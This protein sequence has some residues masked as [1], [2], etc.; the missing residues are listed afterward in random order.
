VFC[1]LVLVVILSPQLAKD[2]LFRGVA[3]S[4]ANVSGQS[5]K[6]L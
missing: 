5:S 3:T 4:G 2:L 6:G 1:G